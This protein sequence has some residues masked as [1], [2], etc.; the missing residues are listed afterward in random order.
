VKITPAH[1]FNDFEVG[2]R[3]GLPMINVLSRDA[4]LDIGPETDF[5]HGVEMT[6]ALEDKILEWNGVFRFA[7]RTMI[8][9]CMEDNGYLEETEPYLHT[10]P[11]GDRSGAVIEPYLTD[12]W[13]VDAATLAKPAIEAVRRGRTNF[14]PKNWES[15]YFHW[16]ENIQ[17]WC[18]SRQLWWGHQIP[19]WYGPEGKVFVAEDESAAI[20]LAK[21]HYGKEETLT[22]DDDVLDTWFSSALWP[23]TT[24]GWPDKT[25]ELARYYPTDVLVTGFDIIF[26]WVARM[27]MMGLHFMDE[28]PFRDIYIHALVRDGKGQKMSKSKGNVIDPI[29]LIDAYG[30]DALRF[31]LAAMAAQGRDIKLSSGRVEGYRNFATKLWNASRFAMMNDCIPVEGFDPKE[32]KTTLNRWIAGELERAVSAVTEALEGFRFNE[33]AGA[34]YHFIWHIYCDWYLELIKPVFVGDDEAAKAETRAM[35]AYVLD[36]AL[37]LL[38]PFMPFVTEELWEKR[39]PEG[40]PRET[41]LILSPWPTHQ[42]LQDAAAD[43]EIG[44][45]IRLVTDVRSVRAEMNVP[46]GRKVPLVI[47]G[48]TDRTRERVAAHLETVSRLAR[49]ESIDFAET[50]PAGSVQ[51]VLD[52]ATIALPLQG[53]IDIDAEADRLKREIDKVGAEITQI[54]AK[55]ANDKFVSRAPQH[56]VEEQRERKADAEAMATKLAQA[57]KRLEAAL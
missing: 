14:A 2:K 33:A 15:T 28:V 51:I 43:E 5:M 46:A 36:K 16:M 40:T 38:H 4:R 37:Q 55:L 32:A 1:D 29:E 56:V 47:A 34:V 6:P 7:A 9:E 45:V 24:L 21:A 13:Y 48:A 19:A 22:R 53:V 44:W 20:A 41:L 12:Q 27:M 54:D 50:P 18:I 10:V 11:Q 26:F 39:A 31:T 3:H 49:I 35:A 23:F 17:P 30:A 25:P 42:G 57:L 8:V 52:E